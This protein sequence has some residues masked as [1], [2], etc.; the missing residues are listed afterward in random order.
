[1]YITFDDALT[2]RSVSPEVAA[3]WRL[4]RGEPV[5]LHL[6]LLQPADFAA[7]AIGSEPVP[8]ELAVRVDGTVL[9]GL[10]L[11]LHN[12][13]LCFVTRQLPARSGP[14]VGVRDVDWQDPRGA[15][16]DPAKPSTVAPGKVWMPSTQRRRA[17]DA[18][19]TVRYGLDEIIAS[20]RSALQTDDSRREAALRSV[21]QLADSLNGA[22]N[23]L[24]SSTQRASAAP[25]AER[26]ASVE[27]ACRDAIKR[28]GH[29]EHGR[30]LAIVYQHSAT[31]DRVH[32]D[33]RELVQAIANLLRY[34]EHYGHEAGA[35]G[36]EVRDDL[37]RSTVQLLLT[38]G[39]ADAAA[40]MSAL[41]LAFDGAAPDGDSDSGLAFARRLVDAACG[42][43]DVRF[44]E[45]VGVTITLHLPALPATQAAPPAQR[46]H[47]LLIEDELHM[48]QR[49]ASYLKQIGFA[50]TATSSGVA[51][52]ESLQTSRPDI[53]LLD[54]VLPDLGGKEILRLLRQH[55]ATATTPVIVVSGSDDVE[56]S[57]RLGANAHLVKPV[58]RDQ[59]AEV[60]NRISPPP[61]ATT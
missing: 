1:M 5:Q 29:L 43:T 4:P 46:G 50:V 49:L 40:L 38:Y 34:F 55:S 51:A 60:V 9:Q 42:Q 16:P 36:V 52:L 10:L 61:P 59:L 54:M 20:A 26:L 30:H 24:L 31:L 53:I 2:I 14:P 7:T 21:L 8:A 15:G 17:S 58:W 39:A 37:E 19:A 12:G 6:A 44:E 41:H 18:A 47:A 57:M 28:S 48:L 45:G 13:R 33:E 11:R 27:T 35:L 22:T 3:L 25:G 32:C 23:Q 56:S